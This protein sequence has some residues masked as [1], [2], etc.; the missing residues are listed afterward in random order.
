MRRVNPSPDRHVRPP[1][2][3]DRGFAEIARDGGA[4]GNPDHESV[5]PSFGSPSAGRAP[6]QPPRETVDPP[7]L[8]DPAP[9]A[10]SKAGKAPVPAKPSKPLTR[11]TRKSKPA[12]P[13]AA[14]RAGRRPGND[15]PRAQATE[16]RPPDAGKAGERPIAGLEAAAGQD[17]PGPDEDV[18][19]FAGFEV[20]AAAGPVRPTTSDKP[21]SSGAFPRRPPVPNTLPDWSRQL[22]GRV[23][24]PPSSASWFMAGAALL[25]ATT[26]LSAAYITTVIDHDPAPGAA[27][28]ATRNRPIALSLVR[29]T[30]TAWAPD[31]DT[32]SPA[33]PI[34]AAS[35]PARPPVTDAGPSGSAPLQVVGVPQAPLLDATVG[36]PAG[37]IP[38]RI[39]RRP[40]PAVARDWGPESPSIPARP[41]SLGPEV[42]TSVLRPLSLPEPAPDR[43]A[44]T[45]ALRTAPPLQVPK[46]GY[47]SLPPSAETV[48]A[49]ALEPSARGLP[50]VTAP[51][52]RPE[53]AVVEPARRALPASKPAAPETAPSEPTSAPTASTGP[54]APNPFGEALLIGSVQHALQRAGLNPGPVDGILGE[55]TRAAIRDYQRTMGAEETGTLTSD[56]VTRLTTVDPL[57][58]N[59]ALPPSQPAAG[60]DPPPA[61][62]SDGGVDP[63]LELSQDVRWG[64]PP[65]DTSTGAASEAGPVGGSADRP[66]VGRFARPADR[67]ASTL[68]S[69]GR[70]DGPGG[71]SDSGAGGPDPGGSGAA[72]SGASGAGGSGGTSGAGGPGGTSSAGEPGGTSDAVGANGSGSSGSGAGSGSVGSGG[73]GSGSVGSGSVGSGGAGS[74]SVGGPVGGIGGAVGGSVGGGPG[75][76][77]GGGSGGGR[78]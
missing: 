27:D 2:E 59:P 61:V 42:P 35:E 6:R 20:L 8:G 44:P 68:A 77:S 12:P 30:V 38:P 70:P 54:V 3:W 71:A 73:A 56:L 65:G 13:T 52:A 46:S 55:R 63:S 49:A 47:V 29:E 31:F 45:A 17:R 57:V 21:S 66:L 41:P 60:G 37:R 10:R 28:Q 50:P 5:S 74:G 14:A 69:A 64:V 15:R 4:G 62:A 11:A 32:V 7:R 26:G 18:P 78:R 25:V 75:G 76:G 16:A 1:P 72:G 39:E 67:P 51:M 23:P 19:A 24:W 48:D 33:R 22:L 58:V 53:S 36:A 43:L 9:T 40:E 34:V